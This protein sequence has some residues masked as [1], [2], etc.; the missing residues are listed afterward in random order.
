MR[1]LAILVLLVAAT[2]A[3]AMAC[4]C[5]GDLRL[6]TRFSSSRVVGIVQVVSAKLITDPKELD[7][8]GSPEVHARAV[9]VESLKGK[10]RKEITLVGVTPS[11][12]CFDPIFVG[13]FYLIFSD[14]REEVSF[15]ACGVH[16]ALRSVPDGMLKAWRGDS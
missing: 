12:G 6:E 15:T 4:S 10:S 5:A 9:L 2:S 3:P 8:E 16:P 13:E 1:F 11:H 7:E 14:G